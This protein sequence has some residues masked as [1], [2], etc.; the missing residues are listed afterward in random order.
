MKKYFMFENN[1]I[2]LKD[3]DV[4]KCILFIGIKNK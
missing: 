4:F 3:K 2:Y 1:V